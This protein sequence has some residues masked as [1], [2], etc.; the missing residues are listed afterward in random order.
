LKL[1]LD[2]GNT[3][4]KWGLRHDG[5][6]LNQGSIPTQD[7]HLVLPLLNS[8]HP[9]A[10]YVANVSSKRFNQRLH[11][12]SAPLKIATFYLTGES[13]L[14]PL[15]NCY[16]KPQELG[17]DRWLSLF[18]ARQRL[19]G[20]VLVVNSGTATT[21][22]A[23]NH[24]HRFLGGIIIP[25]L[26]MMTRALHVGTA[27][28]PWVTG[29]AD[30]WPKNSANALTRGAID[31][32]VGAIMERHKQFIKESDGSSISLI[33]SGGNAPL[34]SPHLSL[35]HQGV[36]HLTLQGLGYYIDQHS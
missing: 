1:A 32:T 7:I 36:E 28:L 25:G 11:E 9:Q 14:A 12:M 8:Y 24:D 17:V 13:Q 4:I 3:F 5:A 6:W 30:T 15:I 22:D 16:D 19:Q 2:I 35:P 26:T 29:K 18:A 31:A 23:L 10:L 33:L 34:I 21:I 20:S 27:N